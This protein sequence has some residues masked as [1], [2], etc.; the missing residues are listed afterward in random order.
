LT[1]ASI[2]ATPLARDRAVLDALPWPLAVVDRD[3]IVAYANPAWPNG[4]EMLG[5]SFEQVLA[6]RR[7]VPPSAAA[8]LRAAIKAAMRGGGDGA[9]LDFAEVGDPPA[10][11]LRVR[12]AAI[13]GGGALVLLEDVSDQ[14]RR[15]LE[16]ALRA[17]ADPLTGLANRRRF[18]TEG[19]RMLALAARHDWGMALLFIDLD[20]FKRIN[21]SAGHTFGDAVLQQVATRLQRDTRCGDLLARFGGDEFVVLLND[22][23]PAASVALAQR[24]RAAIKDP[25]IVPGAALPVQASIGIASFPGAATNLTALLRL[26]DAAMYRAKTAPDGVAVVDE[27]GTPD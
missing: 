1:D 15:E 24:Y 16:L 9:P 25:P 22:I 18:L 8:T 19:A 13:A 17:D 3:G 6:E 2:P 4:A 26:A 27:S 7:S 23:A 10:R 20:G 14:R 12:C 21:D 5:C 11:W